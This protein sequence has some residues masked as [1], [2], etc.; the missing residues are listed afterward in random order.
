MAIFDNQ[1]ILQEHFT[2]G[3]EAY[4]R[5]FNKH[6]FVALFL[7]GDGKVLLR[8]DN[9]ASWDFAIRDYV[10]E[11]EWSSLEGLQRAIKQSFGF[12]F[13]FGDVAPSLTTTRDKLI[14]DFYVIHGYDVETKELCGDSAETFVWME[15]EKARALLKDEAIARYPSSLID[16]LLAL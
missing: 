1:K 12:D 14:L 6:G 16:Y 3:E 8:K 10:L 15:K 11:E 13:F 2:C 5:C 9:A 4:P 7:N